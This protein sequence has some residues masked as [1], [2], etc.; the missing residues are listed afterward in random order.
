M[1]AKQDEPRELQKRERERE[2]KKNEIFDALFA[3]ESGLVF[4][5]IASGWKIVS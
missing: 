5:W 3:N 2:E 1:A 4:Q